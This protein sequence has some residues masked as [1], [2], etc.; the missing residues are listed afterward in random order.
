MT[1]EPIGVVESPVSEGVD[2][3]WGSVESEI[4]VDERYSAGLRGLD[5]FS[6][7]LVVFYM[8][9]SSFDSGTHLVRRPQERGDMPLLGIFAQRAKHRPNPIGVTA[10]EL[11]GVNGNRVRVRGLD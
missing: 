2:A 10:A 7:I 6:H 1:V 9:R 3:D 5:G 8:H 4:V 11:L